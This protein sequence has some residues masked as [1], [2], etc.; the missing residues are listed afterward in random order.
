MVHGRHELWMSNIVEDAVAATN[1]NVG[2]NKC[3]RMVHGRHELWMSNIV[4]D[5]VAATNMNV[6]L[7]KCKLHR[8]RP[9]GGLYWI[10]SESWPG[11]CDQN[12][13]RRAVWASQRNQR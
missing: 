5:A 12:G 6:G 3:K 4:E 1:M 13:G 9:L 10:Q 2:L 11:S 8:A 7:N